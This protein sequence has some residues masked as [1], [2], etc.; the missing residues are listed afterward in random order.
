MPLSGKQ[1]SRIMM[2]LKRHTAFE[3]NKLLGRSGAFW[4]DE[5]YDHVVRDREELGR[6][7]EYVLDN[8]IQAGLA[9]SRRAWQWSYSRY[10][11]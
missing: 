5:S 9:H 8:P 10:E 4:Q 6:I 7:I 3:A 11:L 1:V 2:S